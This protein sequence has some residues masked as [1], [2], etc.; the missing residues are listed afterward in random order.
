MTMRTRVFFGLL[1]LAA[2]TLFAQ[3]A[4][5]RLE[6]EVSSIKPAPPGDP[7]KISIKMSADNG[8]IDFANVSIRDVVLRAY[9]L[10]TYQLSG[11][12][13]IG[14]QRY[15]ISAKLP[16]GATK[17]QIPQML[18]ALLQDRFKLTHHREK[19]ELPVY[20]LVVGKGGPKLKPAESDADTAVP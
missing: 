12:D 2:A 1:P 5:P 11:P 20:S 18:Q 10:K 16:D 14:S 13:W 9:S 3:S 7:H 4:S 8:R 15:D 19:K 6:F 17:D